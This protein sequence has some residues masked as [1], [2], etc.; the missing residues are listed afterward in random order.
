MSKRNEEIINKT[1]SA[2][3]KNFFNALI[4]AADEDATDSILEEAN[5]KLTREQHKK[6]L[7][8]WEEFAKD[9]EEYL[10]Q[11]TS[12]S[13]KDKGSAKFVYATEIPDEEDLKY[14]WRE[15]IARKCLS[16]LYGSPGVGKSFIAL[17]IAVQLAQRGHSVLIYNGEEVPGQVGAKIR[18]LIPPD[19][20]TT[21]ELIL[22]RIRFFS[23]NVFPV[24]G[25]I[26]HV[27]EQ[28]PVD[29]VLLDPLVNITAGEINANDNAK[30]RSVLT[31]LTDLAA[32]HNFGILGVH[33]EVKAKRGFENEFDLLTGASSWGAVAR[34]V[35]RVVGK[36]PRLMSKGALSRNTLLKV[37]K[38]G[39]VKNVKSNIGSVGYGYHYELAIHST[40]TTQENYEEVVKLTGLNVEIG[41]HRLRTAKELAD[42]EPPK[43]EPSATEKRQRRKLQRE[44]SDTS[45]FLDALDKV[46]PNLDERKSK[47]E[48]IA[49]LKELTLLSEAYV[50]RLLKE[51]TVGAGNEGRNY[52][53]KRKSIS[54]PDPIS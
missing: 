48:L 51:H 54:I 32:I 10:A 1:E 31:Q 9:Q 52:Y 39:I 41:E 2:K 43:P 5:K 3:V 33:H 22:D 30:V 13:G 20:N 23:L 26:E 27:V 45:T 40:R 35:L 21:K 6:L 25:V 47:P 4:G 14:L 16:L 15:S 17:K 37:D 42:Y 8:D 44:D 53:R 46:L 12:E 38:C 28:K 11:P 36:E 34:C 18:Q 29:F 7:D 19:D 49:E 50:L 24:P